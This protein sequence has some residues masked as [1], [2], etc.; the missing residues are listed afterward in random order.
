MKFIRNH[1][2]IARISGCWYARVP[3]WQVGSVTEFDRSFCGVCMDAWLLLLSKMTIGGAF[4]PPAKATLVI[5]QMTVTGSI[6]L[7]LAI[8]I[9][10]TQVS[11]L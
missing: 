11:L 6:H 10:K 1:A 8:S 5:W 2:F 4:P 7:T 3:Q 9:T